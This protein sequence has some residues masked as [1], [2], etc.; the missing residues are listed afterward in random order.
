AVVE[1]NRSGGG[2]EAQHAS[3]QIDGLVG[4]GVGRELALR[5]RTRRTLGRAVLGR[6]AG[7]RPRLLGARRALL[8]PCRRRAPRPDAGRERKGERAGPQGAVRGIELR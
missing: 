7:G 3:A 6:I 1:R 2:L 8:R 5:T 4:G